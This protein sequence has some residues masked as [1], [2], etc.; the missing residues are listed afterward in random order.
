[1]SV[2]SERLEELKIGLQEAIERNSQAMQVAN[3]EREKAVAINGAILELQALEPPG[4]ENTEE[5]TTEAVP[6]E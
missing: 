6:A 2:I 1:M 4:E 3:A 5:S